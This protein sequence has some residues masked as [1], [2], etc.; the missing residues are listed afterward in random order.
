[1]KKLLVALVLLAALGAAGFWLLTAPFTY[2]ALRGAPDVTVAT[3]PN[4]ENGKTLF[5]AGGCT[6]CHAIPGQDDRTR[7]GGGLGLQSPFGTFYAPNISPH[8][9]DGIGGWTVASFI[10]AMREGVSPDGRHYYPAFPYTSYQRMAAQDLADVFAFL[11]TLP[12]VEGKV[13]DHDLP[14]PF[15]VRRG[16]GLWK[17]AFLDGKPI[18]PDPAKSAEWNRGRYL[19]EGPGHCAEC[20]SPRAFTGAIVDGKR[21]SGGPDPEGKGFVPNITQDKAGLA[22]WSKNDIAELL[23]TG[24]TP[25]YD[26]VGG[27]MAP[28]IKN[29]SQLSDADRGA[30]AEYI[31]S[32]PAVASPPRP[33]KKAE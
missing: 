15:N 21:F 5:Y 19:V 8:P 18:Q 6:S 9:R 14:F 25:E 16:L 3:A 27:S 22:S 17:L 29:T 33:P 13:R 7:L 12:P 11:K 20:H 23:K 24:F 1:M 26:A 2:E 10:R 32:L 28:V 31:K 4:L 30:M